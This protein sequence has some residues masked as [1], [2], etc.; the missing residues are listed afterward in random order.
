MH[1][2]DLG[3]GPWASK[4][5]TIKIIP[6]TKG[7]FAIIDEEDFEKV[8]EFSW[9]HLTSGKYGYAKRGSNPQ[10]LL[11]RFIMNAPKGKEVDHINRDSL[12]CRKENLRVCTRSQNTFNHPKRKNN[13]SGYVG[14]WLNKATGLYHAEIMVNYKKKHLGVFRLIEGAIKSRKEAEAE[15][16]KNFDRSE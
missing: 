12:D 15:Y 1:I 7:Q 8:S 10:I 16:Y 2:K 4:M 11:H 5:N 13:T 9:H 14:V 6:L 3:V